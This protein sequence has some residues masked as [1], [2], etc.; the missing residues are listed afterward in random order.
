MDALEVLH[1][2]RTFTQASALSFSDI[3]HIPRTCITLI[4]DMSDIQLPNLFVHIWL[5]LQMFYIFPRHFPKHH[6]CFFL[7]ILDTPGTC[8][9]FILTFW[10]FNASFICAHSAD[11]PEVLH[12]FRA[13]FFFWIFGTILQHVLHLAYLFEIFQIFST[14]FLCAHS[15]NAPEVPHFFRTFT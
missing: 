3:L 9:I 1:F 13:V 15:V 10:T 6:G 7:D 11:A 14:S 2:P 4:S 12:F 8:I 5:M